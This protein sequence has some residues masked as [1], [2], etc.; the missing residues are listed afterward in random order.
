MIKLQKLSYK[1][2]EDKNNIIKE[3]LLYFNHKQ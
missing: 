1:V 3:S 2:L